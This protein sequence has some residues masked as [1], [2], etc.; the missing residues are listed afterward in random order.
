MLQQQGVRVGV[1]YPEIRPLK[2]FTPSALLR[3]HFQIEKRV[4]EGIP[5]VRM[6]GWNLFPKIL[7]GTQWQWKQAVYRLYEEYCTSFGRPTLIHAQSALWG[8]VAAAALSE[9]FSIP[10]LVSEHRD[11]FLFEDLN[12]KASQNWLKPLLKEV[13]SKA[14]AVTT[15]SRFLQKGVLRY[16][17]KVSVIPN[18]IDTR[19]FLPVEKEANPHFIFLTVGNL[20]KSKNIDTLL[21]AYALL[22]KEDKEVLL[23][24]VGA[25]PER[26]ILEAKAIRLGLPVQFRG[27]VLRSQI[28]DVYRKADAFVLPSC[29]ETFGIVFVEAMAMG[30]PSIGVKGGG[31]E[32][33]LE[34]GGGLLIDQADP[35]LL[36]EAM[37]NLKN[38]THRYSREALHAKAS[39]RYGQDTIIQKWIEI[40]S[41]YN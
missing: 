37:L 1:I 36:K 24:V 20:M 13:F 7:Q 29:V 11:N 34:E 9:R 19:H 6:H 35:K 31:P 33:I 30:L 2:S 22:Q 21:D 39:S 25:G 14:S 23:Q 28:R 40:Y 10:Y 16:V 38:D 18:F 8:G 26:K 3:N 5:T 41:H 15:V 27:A 4:E 17:N 32:E 12:L